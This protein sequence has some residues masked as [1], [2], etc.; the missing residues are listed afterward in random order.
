MWMKCTKE[1]F[2]K[3]HMVAMDT[4]VFVVLPY[5]WALLWFSFNI[6]NRRE[7][8]TIFFTL[9]ISTRGTSRHI[10]Q[11]M[12]TTLTENPTTS[13]VQ[14]FTNLQEYLV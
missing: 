8:R 5:S 3:C 12:S 9:Q 11:H 6:W 13:D 14:D 7:K 1:D 2:L 4:Y 10:C